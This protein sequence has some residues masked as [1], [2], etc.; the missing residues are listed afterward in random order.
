M[1]PAPNGVFKSMSD[2]INLCV[3]DK[4]AYNN[5]DEAQQVAN[6]QMETDSPALDVYRCP[7]N[8]YVWHL[9]RMLSDD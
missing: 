1:T 3:C 5:Q 9:S 4:G 2:E 8:E 6:H 7:H